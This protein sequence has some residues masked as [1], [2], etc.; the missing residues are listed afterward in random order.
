MGWGPRF[1]D[2][3]HTRNGSEVFKPNGSSPSAKEEGLTCIEGGP[4]LCLSSLSY[5]PSVVP[6]WS[7]KKSVQRL[8]VLSSTHWCHFT[9]NGVTSLPL[10]SL[11]FQLQKS[12]WRRPKRH[13]RGFK[14]AVYEP[15][16]DFTLVTP[17]SYIRTMSLARVKPTRV[18]FN[19][20]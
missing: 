7:P 2:N 3:K 15:M 4:T 5:K 19:F 9:S 6:F 14:T 8:V 13:P 10:V 18:N 12:R 11:H 16:G 20:I 17:P 1:G